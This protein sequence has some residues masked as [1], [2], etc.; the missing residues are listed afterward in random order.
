[1]LRD[2]SFDLEAGCNMLSLVAH[3]TAAELKLDRV[4]EWVDAIGL[5]HGSS[6]ALTDLLARTANAHEPFAERLRECHTRI[7][8]AG[9]RA[10]AHSVA[11]DPAAAVRGLLEAGRSTLNAKLIDNARSVLQRHRG[12]IADADTLLA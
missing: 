6:K 10:M 7:G 3:L 2:E 4:E 8:Q 1:G 12:R 11:G 5:R 9:E